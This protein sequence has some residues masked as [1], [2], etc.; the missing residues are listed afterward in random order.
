MDS[1]TT[2]ADLIIRA[3][4]LSIPI[5]TIHNA[6][7]MNAVGACG[8]QLYN[9]GQTISIPFFTDSWK[10]DSFYDRIKENRNLGLHTLCLLDI[11]V[12]EQSTEKNLA[13]GRKIYEPPRYMTINQAI[14]QLLEIEE[15]RK[16]NAY[17]YETLAIGIA[18]LGSLTEQLIKAGTLNQL[19]SE[20]FGPPLHSLVIVGNR[21]HII[22]ADYMRYFVADKN[23]FD[24]IVKRDYK[25]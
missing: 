15:T 18:R 17:T 19:L 3:K 13:R 11:K 22:E 6:S 8:L 5:Q 23:K 12:K 16:Q 10:P 24:E 1:A 4:E 7:I 20:D 9:F 21:M 25:V 2:H 14:M